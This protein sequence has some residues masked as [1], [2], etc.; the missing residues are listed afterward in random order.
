MNRRGADNLMG[1]AI[2]AL[3][4][5]VLGLLTR[6]M[7]AIPAHVPLDPNEGWNAAHAMALT[8]GRGLYPPQGAFMVN[9]Y[10]PLSFYIVAA[11][12][13]LT[14]DFIV[15]GRILSLLAFL[16]VCAGIA[17][18]ARCMDATRQAA[19]IGALFFAA[20]LLATSDYVGMNDPQLLGH[21]VQIAALL[22]VLAHAP[23]AAAALFAASLFIKHNLLA[24]P[25]ACAIW[26]LWQDRRAG[27]GFIAAGL[28][29]AG[30]G[31]IGFR[32]VH[33]TGLLSQIS[34]PRL[35]SFANVRAGMLHLWWAALP[36]VAMI[37]LR[38]DRWGWLCLIYG[39]IALVLG[40][41]F[42]AGD[43]VDANAF[44]DLTIALSLA[45]ALTAEARPILAAS[46]AAPLVI[47][48]AL[49]FSDNNFFFTRAFADQSAHD[50][51]FLKSHPGP[52][53]CDQLSLCLWAKKDAE[54]DVFNTGEAIES[55]ARDPA[56]LAELITSRHFTVIQIQDP[57]ALGPQVHQAIAHNYR[58]DHSDDNGNFLTP[59]S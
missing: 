22:L 34:S 51:A 20:A 28:L 41:A 2:L 12:A 44:F 48:L 30:A 59:D 43:G 10:P 27:L 23:I 40:A 11:L 8:A 24:L 42:S 14:G 50:I 53:L 33:G 52:A 16:I 6:N 25:L 9:N 7:L 37:S 35:A 17:I 18:L 46:A 47:F 45:L 5:I 29:F 56:S 3:A 54:V 13:R 21:A 36:L 31:L 58:L 38:R 55:G 57:D 39:A 15:A 26:L 19:M 4:A 32:L 1:C 49:N